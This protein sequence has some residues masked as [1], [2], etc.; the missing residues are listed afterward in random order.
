MGINIKD[1]VTIS[2]HPVVHYKD[3][4]FTVIGFNTSAKTLTVTNKLFGHIFSWPAE[5]CTKVSQ[6][7]I[8]DKKELHNV[9]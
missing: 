1:T 2:G 3:Q 4:T 6:S 5:L 8:N 9:R 7:F